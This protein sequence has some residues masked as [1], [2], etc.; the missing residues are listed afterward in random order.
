MVTGWR[1]TG[2]P[3]RRAAA[4]AVSGWLVVCCAGV[5][6]SATD[7]GAGRAVARL[8]PVSAAGQAELARAYAAHQ[9]MPASDVGGIRP[10]SV[11]AAVVGSTGVEWA[12]AAF[13]PSAAAPRAAQTRFQDGGAIG[14]FTRHGTSAW[15]MRGVGGEPFPCAGA[16]PAA[17]RKAWGLSIPAACRESGSQ[18]RKLPGLR[19]GTTSTVAS[20]ALSQVGRGDTPASTSWSLDC[21]AYT[22]LV[23][24]GASTAGCGTDPNFGVRDQNEEWCADFAKW[25]WEQAGVGTDLSVLTPSAASFAAWGH[26]RGQSLPFDSGTPAVGD[27]IVFYPAGTSNPVGSYADHV[28]LIAGVNSSSNTVEMVNGDFMGSGNITVQNSG[29]VNIQSFANSIW[30]TGE[31][32]VLVSSELPVAS[33]SPLAIN[34][35]GN[36]VAFVNTSGEVEHDWGNSTGWHGPAPLG[37]TARADSPVASDEAG[38]T[39]VFINPAGQVVNDWA[40]P[41]TGWH[42]PAAIGG[43]ARAGSPLAINAAGNDV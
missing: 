24:V 10:G 6:W 31:K 29:Y 13:T 8:V 14:V 22:A 1:W 7:G 19:A 16:V 9:G 12:T 17:V 32:W 41:A 4:G 30:G 5:A 33:S 26:D 18:R 42:G 15:T 25:V 27:A 21:D 11:H 40:N 20:V 3:L 38:I 43:T 28:G 36:D 37:G 2:R 23:G 35:A 39:V 34:G